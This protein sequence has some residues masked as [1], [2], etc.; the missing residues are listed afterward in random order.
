MSTSSNKPYPLSV[1]VFGSLN[2]DQIKSLVKFCDHLV[3]N[4]AHA[5]LVAPEEVPTLLDS[6]E[7]LKRLLVANGVSNH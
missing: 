6:V 1:H 2:S 5:I 4:G 3:A 7:A